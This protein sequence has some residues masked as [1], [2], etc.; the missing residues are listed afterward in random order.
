[1]SPKEISEPKGTKGEEKQNSTYFIRMKGKSLIWRNTDNRP[2]SQ[3]TRELMANN[4]PNVFKFPR[5][6]QL[7]ED[8]CI[9]SFI[10]MVLQTN[11][12]KEICKADLEDVDSEH[13]DKMSIWDYYNLPP[14]TVSPVPVAIVASRAVDPVGPVPQF[15]APVQSSS[16]PVLHEM[17]SDY[18]CSVAAHNGQRLS[19]ENVSFRP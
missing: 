17:M 6:T 11:W 9:G 15:M 19:V 10:Q 13:F 3:G 2:Q 4:K 14:R 5:R 7:K 16:G 18:N 8:V 12:K 1:M